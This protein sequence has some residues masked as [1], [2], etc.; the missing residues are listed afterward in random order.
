MNQSF[1]GCAIIVLSATALAAGT[2][3]QLPVGAA[4]APV[5]TP[6]FPSPV[7]AFVWR[8]WQV[9]E[10]RKMA[11]VLS[12]SVENV[13]A[14]AA[15]MGLPPAGI[16][17][18]EMKTRGYIT[19]LRRN[20]HL[21]PYEQLLTLVEMSPEQ[22]AYTLRED[23]FLWIKLGSL[24]PKCEPLRYVPPDAAAVRRA[25]EIKRSVEA[26]FGRE[27]GEPGEPRF[28]FV[29]RLS[30]PC[31]PAPQPEPSSTSPALRFIYSY[32]AVYGD[33]L[34]RPEL[35]PYPDGLLDRLAH[36]GVNGVGLHVVLRNLAPAARIF[37]SSAWA[38]SNVSRTSVAWWRGR[39]STEFASISTSM[40][41][42]QCRWTSSPGV[43]RWPASARATTR[44]CVPR[45]RP[46]ARG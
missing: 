9:V 34:L 18:P 27:L 14:L 25:A 35:D 30:E 13:A 8:N 36:V 23:D 37:P 3:P 40:S 33:P 1:L 41:P 43:P 38:M 45:I 21:L 2:E 17:P 42:E 6:H 39:G 26:C 24:K 19:I 7:Y 20:W 4:P 5:A 28:D 15:S 46:F 22:L 44:P 16:I 12:T 31:P 11:Q 29:R 10:P 32:F